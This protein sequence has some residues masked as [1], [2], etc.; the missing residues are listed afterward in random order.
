MDW[1]HL[2]ICLPF[3]RCWMLHAKVV[4]HL[5]LEGQRSRRPRRYW[6]W[7]GTR[8][9]PALLSR[10]QN[11]PDSGDWK[12]RRIR[13]V[14]ECSHSFR[15]FDY[16]VPLIVPFPQ[17]HCAFAI[18]YGTRGRQWSLKLHQ[19]KTAKNPGPWQQFALL[20]ASRNFRYYGRFWYKIGTAR[21]E[22]G[23]ERRNRRDKMRNPQKF[24]PRWF[25]LQRGA[26]SYSPP[27]GGRWT[28]GGRTPKGSCRRTENVCLENAHSKRKT[29]RRSYVYGG[30]DE[31]SCPTGIHLIIRSR[32]HSKTNN[33]TQQRYDEPEIRP[34]VLGSHGS[35]TFKRIYLDWV[36]KDS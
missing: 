24:C 14:G 11:L 10:P 30:E 15:S 23:R 22:T 28:R 21:R 33:G 13:V 17:D 2:L 3:A 25:R 16:R 20:Y 6:G 1:Y 26:G 9:W 31:G 18:V 19:V 36:T 29:I 7:E 27:G 4:E 35:T 32:I 8:T 34:E 12:D 5:P